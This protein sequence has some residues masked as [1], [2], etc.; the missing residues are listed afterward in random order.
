MV[1]PPRKSSAEPEGTY[2]PLPEKA[3]PLLGSYLQMIAPGS[4]HKGEL[5][6]ELLRHLENL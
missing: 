3:G 1:L 6:R 5:L 4:I 2:K